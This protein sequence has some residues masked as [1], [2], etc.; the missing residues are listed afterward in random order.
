MIRHKQAPNVGR[1]C[2]KEPEK[3]ESDNIRGR[4]ARTERV[5]L[6]QLVPLLHLRVRGTRGSA[7]PTET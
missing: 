4:A 6:H 2:R 5:L 7:S 1:F 3:R